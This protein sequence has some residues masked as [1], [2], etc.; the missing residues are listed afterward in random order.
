M[1]QRSLRNRKDVLNQ[2]KN[3][4]GVDAGGVKF[5]F[6]LYCKMKQNKSLFA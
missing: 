3:L 2:S 5:S 1:L 6:N 4:V